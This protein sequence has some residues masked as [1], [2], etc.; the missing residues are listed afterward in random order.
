MKRLGFRTRLTLANSLLVILFAIFFAAYFPKLQEDAA[1][2]ALRSRAETMANVFA[3]VAVAVLE[4][5]E[6]QTGED[7]GLN[8]ELLVWAQSDSDLAYANVLKTDKTRVGH[9]LGNGT[10]E[11]SELTEVPTGLSFA[12][13]DALIHVSIPVRHEGNVVGAVNM[14]FS[15]RSITAARAT[16]Q[17]TALTVSAAVF[18][19]GLVLAF[20]VGRSLA[21]PLLVSA[22]E[23]HTVSQNIVTAT[24]GQEASSAEEA[25]AV[26]QTRQSMELLL[27]SAQ[28]IAERSS[29]VLGNAERNAVGSKQI[30]ERIGELNEQRERITEILSTIMQ[31]A[32]K[33]DLL[34]LNASLEGT[35][36]GEAGK[37]FTLVAA[38]MRRLA[39]NVMESVTGIRALMKEMRH[40]SQGAVE[41]SSAGTESSEATT[42]SARE[43]ALLT[44][45]QRQAT[46]QVIASMSEMAEI[47]NQNLAA[48]RRSSSSAGRLASVADSLA[49]L[50]DASANGTWQESASR[51]DARPG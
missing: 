46:E 31:V 30:A 22:R 26:A 10:S 3:S 39:E 36:A 13:S 7:E 35:K 38:E 28:Q 34:A 33:A 42:R 17:R 32:D 25:A 47:L 20:L 43:I 24:K 14:G 1:E 49:S 19:I 51:S 4:M 8:K 40:A 29:E 41:A 6:L 45:E 11:G 18:V 44:Q 50:L 12:Q 15:D 21:G 16:S 27:D 23:V 5:G 9:Y 37:G 48:I 2:K